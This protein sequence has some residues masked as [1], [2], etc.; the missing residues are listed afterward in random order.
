M[1][2]LFNKMNETRA[3]VGAG[4]GVY[5]PHFQDD[6]KY[7]LLAPL[8]SVP[9]IGKEV[10]E[11]E[12]KVASS[13]DV[14]KLATSNTYN[15]AEAGVYMHR[16]CIRM[17]EKLD[18]LTIPVLFMAGDFSGQKC[19]CTISYSTE[20]LEQDAPWEGTVKFTP[21]SV[22]EVVYNCYDMVKPTAHFTS[23]IPDSLFLDAAYELAVSTKY[24]G[25]TITAIV[26][27]DK[28]SIVT[29]TVTGN[30][31]TFTPKAKGSA[32]VTLKTTLANHAS[33]ETTVLC[34]VEELTGAE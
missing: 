34:I 6:G 23:R 18:G 27:K 33:W 9:M 31:V 32:L 7:A 2:K 24:E 8:I 1:E 26:E 28:E 5:T 11:T 15:A 14:T 12:I 25:T 13:N 17:L 30:K 19:D 29:A 16:D 22:P 3:R 10:G 4:S 20:N 21:V